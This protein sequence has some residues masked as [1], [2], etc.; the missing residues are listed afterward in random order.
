MTGP[1]PKTDRLIGAVRRENARRAEQRREGERPFA[2]GLAAIG[3]L[4]WLF[5]TPMLLGVLAGRALDR[6][7]ESG[8]FWTGALLVAGAA[9]GYWLAWR[10]MNE[11]GRGR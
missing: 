4:G 1:E 7:A 8:I 9:I 11:M 3:A 6:W 10:R 2:L 5:V